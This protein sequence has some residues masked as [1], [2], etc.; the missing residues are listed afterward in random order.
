MASNDG[1]KIYVE[2]SYLSD[3]EEMNIT[4]ENAWY[5]LREALDGFCEEDLEKTRV[6]TTLRST[7]M[8][9]GVFVDQPG[10][11][12]TVA[13][14]IFKAIDW[15]YQ[16]KWTKE[17]AAAVAR[18]GPIRT[19][20]PNLQILLGCENVDPR[21]WHGPRLT[22]MASYVSLMAHAPVV[23]AAIEKVTP[24]S[25]FGPDDCRFAGS[26]KP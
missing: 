6:T 17:M 7:M 15:D 22:T 5:A 25:P 18:Y 8:R 16:P 1:V 21:F 19:I 26:G 23:P 3:I 9:N 24:S 10:P 11:G 13:S 14:A 2:G 20:D 12:L 4:D